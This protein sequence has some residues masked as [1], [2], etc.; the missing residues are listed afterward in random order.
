MKIK[1]KLQIILITYNRKKYVERTF[2]QLFAGDSPIKDYDILVLDNN[3]DDGTAEYVQKVMIERKNLKYHK[4]KYNL[5]LSGNIA[6]ALET[7]NKEYLWI[8]CDDDLYDWNN[9]SEVESAIN[10]GEELLCVARYILPNDKKDDPAY[11]LFQM[12]FL[13]ASIFKTDLLNDTVMMNTF[14]NIYTLFPHLCP[15]IS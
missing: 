5:G 1:D 8:I 4:N 12:T 15:I 2:N 9:W 7:A 10:K 11:Q 3:S 6:K 13:P 14:S